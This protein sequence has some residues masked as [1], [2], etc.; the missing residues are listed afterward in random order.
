MPPDPHLALPAA[1]WTPEQVQGDGGAER[2]DRLE[3]L[4]LP[5]G[6]RRSSILTVG[7]S[8]RN[9]PIRSSVFHWMTHHR[10]QAMH[11]Y[12]LVILRLMPMAEDGQLY[13]RG[14]DSD[15]YPFVLGR[16]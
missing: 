12:H 1:G 4:H 11:H 16:D 13:R 6:G 2:V 8:R 3:N 7:S 10:T 9:R 15:L 14:L 5:S